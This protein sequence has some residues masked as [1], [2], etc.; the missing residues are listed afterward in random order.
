[1]TA[2]ASQPAPKQR[3]TQ[4][5]DPHAFAFNERDEVLARHRA[6]LNAARARSHDCLEKA[7]AAQNWAEYIGPTAKEMLVAFRALVADQDFWRNAEFHAVTADPKYEAIRT[8][9]LELVNSD[10]AGLLNLLGYADPP[11][12]SSI[13]LAAD[14]A[15][16]FQSILDYPDSALRAELV[17]QARRRLILYNYRLQRLLSSWDDSGANDRGV[18]EKLL[19]AL[20]RG[21]AA[22]APG[23]LAAGVVGA[24]FPP[25]GA[26]GAA[27][28]LAEGIDAGAKEFLESTIKMSATAAIGSALAGEET[29][30]QL[31][32]E[33]Q[34][35]VSQ[36]SYLSAQ[37]LALAT[38]ES[39]KAVE[40]SNHLRALS[41]QTT[42]Y[43]FRLLQTLAV[44]RELDG[45]IAPPV[46]N[47]IEGLNLLQDWV[48]MP[49]EPDWQD[50]SAS[51]S[52]SL[53]IARDKLELFVK[54]YLG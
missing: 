5:A 32:D 51:F 10:L 4:P 14:V 53:R 19:A 17:L 38:V 9:I 12:P 36:F 20:K 28:A 49:Y 24:L 48:E 39:T 34:A 33:F 46:H 7:A 2:R 26:V 22:A 50:V 21:A 6:R 30:P 13:E 11:P 54:T 25:A 27:A 16:S 42:R 18:G 35:S 52:S 43:A 3:Q 29:S 47:A 37:L 23:V 44:A 8:K 45:W 15:V 31:L 41:I 1:M 40:F